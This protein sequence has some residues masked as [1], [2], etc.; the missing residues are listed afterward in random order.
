M[1]TGLQN[2]GDLAIAQ[3]QIVTATGNIKMHGKISEDT[4]NK[5]AKEFEGVFAAQMLQPMFEG[6]KVDP[7]FGGGHGE[8]VMRSFLL[9][10]YGKAMSAGG[11][12]GIAAAVKT[13]MIKAQD[14]AATN[15]PNP[16]QGA[17]YV[18]AQ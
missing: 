8:E 18:N 14:A 15:Q 10:E 3:S 6:M 1:D 4:I 11:H 2:I 5:K 16:S 13:A 12:L 17:A 9:Q 7:L